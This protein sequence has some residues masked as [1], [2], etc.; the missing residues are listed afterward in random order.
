MPPEYNITIATIK[1]AQAITTLLNSAYRGKLS[2]QGWT[3]EAHLIG[4]N[5]RTIVSQISNL[6]TQ[7]NSTFYVV[8]NKIDNVVGCVNLQVKPNNKL[9][10]GMLSTYPTLQNNGI[11]KL[12]LQEAEK[13]ALQNNCTAI[14][15]TVISVRHELIAWYNRHGYVATGAIIPFT[16]DSISGKHKQRLTFIELEKILK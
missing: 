14:T 9:Y 6:I 8:F 4:G 1:H 10:L 2:I 15:M 12:L 13:H 16:E 11:G 7:H 5:Q 3:T